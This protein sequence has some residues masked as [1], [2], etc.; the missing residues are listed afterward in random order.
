[1]SPHRDCGASKDS[2]GSF[3]SN[4][5]SLSLM[6]FSSPAMNC[7]RIDETKDSS[8]TRDNDAINSLFV[9]AIARRTILIKKN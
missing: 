7:T 8:K 4:K 6:C 9:A 1:M 2:R 5:Y 3:R